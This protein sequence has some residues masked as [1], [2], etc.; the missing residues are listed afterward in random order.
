MADLS[1]IRAGDTVLISGRGQ[2]FG[3]PVDRITTTFIVCGDVRFN[4]KTGLESGLKSER[5]KRNGRR[6]RGLY[7]EI[8]EARRRT[9]LI[10]RLQAMHWTCWQRL[11]TDKLTRLVAILDEQ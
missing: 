7:H 1:K 4:R 11:S 3:A 8:K 5:E 2:E 6:I 10:D 9:P